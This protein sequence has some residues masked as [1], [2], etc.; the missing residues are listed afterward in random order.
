M[1]KAK[2]NSRA[3]NALTRASKRTVRGEPNPTGVA[4]APFHEIA[5]PIRATIVS[6]AETIAEMRIS[7]VQSRVGQNLAESACSR[8]TAGRP[9]KDRSTSE[10]VF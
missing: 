4:R 10:G 1:D 6:V 3:D 5:P 8:P 2:A 9:A 7:R